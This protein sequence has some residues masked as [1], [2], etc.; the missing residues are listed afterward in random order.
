MVFRLLLLRSPSF[1]LQLAFSGGSKVLVGLLE[2]FFSEEMV[3]PADDNVSGPDESCKGCFD[4][5]HLCEGSIAEKRARR[6]RVIEEDEKFVFLQQ[7]NPHARPYD[8][9]LEG[10][11]RRRFA[12]GFEHRDDLL[13][14]GMFCN[15]IQCIIVHMYTA[16]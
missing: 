9:S 8:I 3:L 6:G 4:N 11:D 12:L 7:T 15:P 13:C 2:L 5:L 14:K 1:D 16:R 10:R